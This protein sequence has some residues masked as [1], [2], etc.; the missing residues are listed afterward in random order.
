M[1]VDPLIKLDGVYLANRPT[2]LYVY[3]HI[4]DHVVLGGHH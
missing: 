4:Q 1:V 2:C 3:E